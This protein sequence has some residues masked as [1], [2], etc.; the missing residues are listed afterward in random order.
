M[1]ARG[2]ERNRL[3]EGMS[4]KAWRELNGPCREGLLGRHLEGSHDGRQAEAEALG[5]DPN[6]GDLPVRDQLGDRANGNPQR[7][8]QFF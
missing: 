3:R 1:V 5:P 4:V 6:E 7:P 8:S 2:I